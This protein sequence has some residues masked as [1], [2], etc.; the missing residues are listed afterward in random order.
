MVA[1]VMIILINYLNWHFFPFHSTFPG[2]TLWVPVGR[3][4]V[5]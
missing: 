3:D 2:N 4:E 1:A 5:E